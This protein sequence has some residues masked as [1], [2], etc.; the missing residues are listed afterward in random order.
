MRMHLLASALVWVWLAGAAAS[1]A[2][3]APGGCPEFEGDAVSLLGTIRL[4]TFPGPPNF[5]SIHR[6]DK[7]IR[8]F[9]LELDQPVCVKAW[10][11]REE[12][13]LPALE[14]VKRV[15][16]LMPIDIP[17]EPEL[18]GRLG[19][20]VWLHG[21]LVAPGS[22]YHY[23]P[24]LIQTRRMTPVF[25]KRLEALELPELPGSLRGGLPAGT[26]AD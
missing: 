15:Q 18:L 8:E 3:P 17:I 11:D 25:F 20:P 2:E 10:P 5:D 21:K 13:P 1:S 9:V 7:T 14:G 23:L 19:E 22:R 26:V 24:L 12:G 16:A 6:G 4:E